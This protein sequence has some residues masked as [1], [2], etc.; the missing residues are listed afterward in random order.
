MHNNLV[1]RGSYLLGRRVGSVASSIF[2]PSE[3]YAL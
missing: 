2:L 1:V 3:P